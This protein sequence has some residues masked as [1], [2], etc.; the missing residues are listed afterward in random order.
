MSMLFISTAGAEEV[1]ALCAEA[2]NENAYRSSYLKNF[3]ILRDGTDGWIFRNHDLKTQFGPNEQVYVKLQELAKRLR[4]H[5][6]WLV[7]V[8]IPVRG[9]IHP[10]KL[11]QIEYDYK[12]G[13]QS[14]ID[15]LN[16]LRKLGILVPR[17]ENLFPKKH[18]KDL[19]FKRDQHWNGHGAQKIAKFT[20]KLIKRTPGYQKLDTIEY[21]TEV[22]G[23]SRIEGSVQKA[24][25]SI[26]KSDYP[27]EEYYLFYTSR[28]TGL[29]LFAKVAE[30]QVVLVGTGN[31][32][33]KHHFNFDGFL[34]QFLSAD[35]INM[36]VSGGGYGEAIK[37]Y[38]SGQDY[39]RNPPRYLIW[40][41]PGYYSLNVIDFIE[42]LLDLVEE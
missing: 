19:Y 36:A 15:F 18:I 20:A 29:D 1:P 26:C 10:E 41:F 3:K 13:R 6:T 5:G 42:E 21:I 37:S 4:K 17:I 14:Y 8:P 11:D 23:K 30:P 39:K 40:E 22:N 7:M 38:L 33:G 16:R 34:R 12:A 25:S 28:K 27:V 2:A 31:S 32:K 35:V 24:A 9:L